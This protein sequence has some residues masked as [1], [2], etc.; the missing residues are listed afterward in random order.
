MLSVAFELLSHTVYNMYFYFIKVLTSD[1]VQKSIQNIPDRLDF[2]LCKTRRRKRKR[3][4]KLHSYKTELWKDDLQLKYGK[5]LGIKV[6]SQE[7]SHK[8]P[9]VVRSAVIISNV[10]VCSM[11]CSNISQRWI[12][13]QSYCRKAKTI[14]WCQ[15]SC[16][17]SWFVPY[18][19]LMIHT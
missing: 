1:Y 15:H 12:M 18:I 17:V 7:L 8:A 9:V 6:I 3:N 4:M 19:D 2:C 13:I 11:F 5:Y 16:P 10:F 14:C